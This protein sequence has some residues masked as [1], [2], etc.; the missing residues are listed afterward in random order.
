MQIILVKH[1]DV[2]I[3]FIPPQNSICTGEKFFRPWL[4]EH[5]R[6]D[7]G[8]NEG[9][10]RHAVIPHVWAWTYCI[11]PQ[12][13]QINHILLTLKF[14]H[15]SGSCRVNFMLQFTTCLTKPRQ[16]NHYRIA[17]NVALQ[18][19]SHTL[20]SP[21]L[22]RSWHSDSFWLATITRSFIQKEICNN[23]SRRCLRAWWRPL[24]WPR[25]RRHPRS[26][27]R[28]MLSCW[29][30]WRQILSTPGRTFNSL[31]SSFEIWICILIQ[32]YLKH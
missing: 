6:F 1:F 30:T 12:E 13:L 8:T 5:R 21:I 15:C 31:K 10:A 19:V 14:R 17:T 11:L 25:H 24:R 28:S 18:H 20:R 29:T 3:V 23:L 16:L 9:L 26:W 2:S 32:N 27:W 22:V 4:L 7:P